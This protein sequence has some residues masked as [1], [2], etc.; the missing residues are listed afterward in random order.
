MGT[1]GG[2]HVVHDINTCVSQESDLASCHQ[3]YILVII[4]NDT[5]E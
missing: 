2:L 5:S 1:T 4:L 3:I